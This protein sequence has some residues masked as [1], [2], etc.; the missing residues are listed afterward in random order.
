MDRARLAMKWQTPERL[1]DL[2]VTQTK[3]RA[4]RGEVFL[5]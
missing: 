3:S 2:I 1:M 4:H 5:R